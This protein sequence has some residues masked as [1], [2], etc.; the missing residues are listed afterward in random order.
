M[1]LLG[2]EIGIWERRVKKTL[3]A[4]CQ[5]RVSVDRRCLSLAY[6]GLELKCSATL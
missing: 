2:L 5:K 4:I 1:T 3:D 6:I